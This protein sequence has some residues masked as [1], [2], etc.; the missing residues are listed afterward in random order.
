DHL[1]LRLLDTLANRLRDFLGLA[2]PEA[3]AATLVTHHDQRAEAESSPT[4]HDLGDAVD[5]H[6]LLLELLTT[7]V[8]DDAPRT[9]GRPFL[10]HRTLSLELEPTLARPLRHGADATVVEESVPIEDH[11]LDALLLAAA[12]REQAHLLGRGH[13]ARLRQLAAQLGRTGPDGEHRL[14]PGI[15]DALRVHALAAAK[16]RPR[17]PLPRAPA[18]PPSAR[19]PAIARDELPTGRHQRDAPAAAAA[20]PAFRRMRSSAYFT[21]FPL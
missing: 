4:L 6:H 21:P 7:R 1:L 11:S 16:P 14:P 20:L 8:R 2:E 13:V 10:S 17:G 12:G 5:V 9:T 3:D 19:P 18:A 15:D